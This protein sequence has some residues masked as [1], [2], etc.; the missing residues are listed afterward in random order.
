MKA[1]AI[2]G[3]PA[4][5][6]TTLMR[7]ITEQLNGKGQPFK[8]GLLRGVEYEQE[9]IIILGV[10]GGDKFG[11]T[12]RLSMAVQPVAE[13]YMN[14]MI[15]TPKY[16]DWTIMFEGDRLFN[17]SFIEHCRG[18]LRDDL[19]IILLQVDKDRLRRRHKDRGDTQTETWL[20]GRRTKYDKLKQ[21]FNPE[22]LSN[23]AQDE[24]KYNVDAI[25]GKTSHETRGKS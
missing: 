14:K 18:L 8:Y 25:L 2:G 5:G 22:I 21:L 12:D 10:Y 13:R 16:R 1:I 6:K 23:D 4:T 19:R 15:I 24:L 9:K 11:G 7:C 17:R 20:K 3:E